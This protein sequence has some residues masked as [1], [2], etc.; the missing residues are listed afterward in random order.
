MNGCKMWHCSSHNK[1]THSLTH[2][3]KCSWTHTHIFS[4]LKLNGTIAFFCHYLCMKS[5][6]YMPYKWCIKLAMCAHIKHA[7]NKKCSC[8]LF[9]CLYSWECKF[10]YENFQLQRCLTRKSVSG[11]MRQFYKF[12]F[13]CLRS[14]HVVL[15]DVCMSILVPYALLLRYS[16][17][18]GNIIFKLH[19]CWYVVTVE[20][21]YPYLYTHTHTHI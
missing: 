20:F 14:K 17:F 2:T 6:C 11:T 19:F 13:F 3:H 10:N 9:V 15:H 1:L 18:D 4:F 12:R 8:Y 7:P 21:L 16:H 5:D